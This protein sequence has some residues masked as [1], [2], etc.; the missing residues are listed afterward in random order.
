MRGFDRKLQDH[1]MNHSIER[2]KVGVAFCRQGAR[3]AFAFDTGGAG[4]FGDA[5]RLGDM[6]Y[7][8]KQHMPAIF[9][10]G[11]FECGF[12]ILYREFG[13][14][15]EMRD[16]ELVVRYAGGDGFSFSSLSPFVIFQISHRAFNIRILPALTA[17]AQQQNNPLAGHAVIQAIAGAVI[18]TQ[19]PHAF[20]ERLAVTSIII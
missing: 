20:P 9:I 11:F 13:I 5:V 1:R 6:P 2:V 10:G 19:F 3:Q 12:Q 8:G 4:D 15:P 17:A 18:N 14:V 7:G 16:D